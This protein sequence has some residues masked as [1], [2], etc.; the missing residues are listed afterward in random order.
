MCHNYKYIQPILCILLM[1][2]IINSI[3]FFKTLVDPYWLMFPHYFIH[4]MDQQ[5][6]KISI[7]FSLNMCFVCSKESSH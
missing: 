5:F 6:F 7:S 4:I 3:P 1:T 2:Y